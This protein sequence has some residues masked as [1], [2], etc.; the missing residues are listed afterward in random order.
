MKKGTKYF[1]FVAVFIALTFVATIAIAIPS[2][3]TSGYINFG[4]TVIFIAASLLGP[5]GGMLC[6][7]IGS[8][9]ADLV[10]SPIWAPITLIVKGLE[11]LVAGLIISALK[12]VLHS[13]RFDLIAPI[14]AYIV[15]AI[16]MIVGYY[17]GGA[18]LL[19]IV[20]DNNIVVAL[21]ASAIDIPGNCLQGGVSVIVGYAI[22]FGIMQIH[23]VKRL[24]DD[25]FKPIFSH[26]PSN[27]NYP[28]VDST[29]AQ[30]PDYPHS[31][32]INFNVDDAVDATS[33]QT[34][35]NTIA[36]TDNLDDNDNTNNTDSDF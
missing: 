32:D 14:P 1:A 18:I 36:V 33:S 8:L 22:Y 35:S 27:A 12:R 28:P 23:Y 17:F 24:R 20:N 25:L 21:T 11:G 30:N 3:S 26:A 5:L 29:K 13:K 16:V 6:G 2:L 19:G 10:F 15:S 9:L 7:G 31:K 34:Q 4:D